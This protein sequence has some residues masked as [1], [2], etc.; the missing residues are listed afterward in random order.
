MKNFNSQPSTSTAQLDPTL[1]R[2]N[3]IGAGLKI[4]HETFQSAEGSPRVLSD[5]F[6]DG[7]IQDE[8][9]VGSE[10]VGIKGYL[11]KVETTPS[12]DEVIGDPER[13]AGLY[14]ATTDVISR[15]LSVRVASDP[16]P[17][18][19][20]Q[21]VSKI[22]QAKANFLDRLTA[23]SGQAADSIVDFATGASTE[24]P[25]SAVQ[26]EG[27]EVDGH[28]LL[29]AG[30]KSDP[31]YRANFKIQRQLTGTFVMA[32]S[33]RKVQEKMKGNPEEVTKRIY[34]NPD[35]EAAP[36]VFE[37]VLQTA[38]DTGLSIQLKIFQRSSEMV[39][40]YKQRQRGESADTLRGDGIVIYVNEQEADDVL[41]MVEAIAQDNPDAFFG[42]QTS[43]I[44]KKVAEGIAVGDE[45]KAGGESL[46]SHRAKI[47]EHA[48][49][50]TKESG[51]TGEEAREIFKRW[52]DVTA[53]ANGVDP[54][55]LAFNLRTKGDNAA[56][57]SS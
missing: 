29:D 45:P 55:N 19:H 40:S 35:V 52:F 22:K 10:R 2:G 57:R 42:R 18:T 32:Y 53:R 47:I 15:N 51:K 39:S 49:L 14:L 54:S 16:D 4:L 34:L 28:D 23:E 13:I 11:D 41:S 6:I 8:L 12:D 1:I 46:T 7:C 9:S 50:K 44:P 37:Q 56:D 30:S 43:R 33:D 48:T 21:R 5:A 36:H 31:G 20:N 27:F 24:Y 17:A 26:Y 25:I 3:N 38:N